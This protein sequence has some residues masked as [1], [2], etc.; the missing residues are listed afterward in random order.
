MKN[1]VAAAILTL[2]STIAALADDTPAPVAPAKSLE[3]ARAEGIKSAGETA[4]KP[5]MA[6]SQV[7]TIYTLLC[8]PKDL[9]REIV[10]SR[11]YNRPAMLAM[12]NKVVADGKVKAPSDCRIS[13]SIAV[14][15]KK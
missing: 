2:T 11:S 13:E 4:A 15:R 7:N 3:E 9:N 1:Y 14:A 8:K 6:A 10:F 12:T 5:G